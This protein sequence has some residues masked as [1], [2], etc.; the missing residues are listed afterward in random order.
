MT[1]FETGIAQWLVAGWKD[2]IIFPDYL[3]QLDS[4][5][6]DKI[7]SEY[8]K[9]AICGCKIQNAGLAASMFKIPLSIV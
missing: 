9:W 4:K 8:V 3:Q 6:R 5:F 7:A 1:S 2:D